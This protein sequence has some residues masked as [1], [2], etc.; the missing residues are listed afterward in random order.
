L[1][2]LVLPGRDE[3]PQALIP[4]AAAPPRVP[5]GVAVLQRLRWDGGEQNV[6]EETLRHA[7]AS[8]DPDVR[9]YAVR[10]IADERIMSLRDDVAGLLDGEAP[11]E[12][13]FLAVLAAIDWLDGDRKMRNAQI[14]DALLLGEL[15]NDA[16]P[17]A[18]HALALRL[19]SPDHPWLSLERLRAYL[20]AE[21]AG[22]RLEAVQRSGEGV[23]AGP[24]RRRRT[25]RR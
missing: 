21:D 9:L 5:Q 10:W 7:L 11:S 12:R 19:L 18:L 22:L 24:D 2:R 8:A 25:P 13:Y 23:A 3:A 4:L 1:W 15:Q 16:R 20:D 6:F 17:P 14:S